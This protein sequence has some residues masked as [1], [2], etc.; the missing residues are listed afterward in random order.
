MVAQAAAPD[1]LDQS[2]ERYSM[3]ALKAYALP[4]LYWNGMLRGRM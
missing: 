4:E 1:P 2:Q 3:Y